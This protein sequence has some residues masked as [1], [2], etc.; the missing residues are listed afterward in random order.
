M[1]KLIESFYVD[2]VVSG[3]SDEEE[4]FKL[5]TNS[6]RILKKAAFNLQKFKTN[7]QSL[8][9]RIDTVEN[10]ELRTCKSVDDNTVPKQD[11]PNAA[12]NTPE[13]TSLALKVLG[14]TWDPQGDQLYFIVSQ[15]A[16]AAAAI[17]LTK[18]N[19]VRIIGKFYDPTGF[20][21]PV[22]IPFKRFFQK[23]CENQIQW[24]E[25][26]PNM[27][28]EEW[29]PLSSSLHSSGCYLFLEATSV[30][31]MKISVPVPYM[32]ASKSVRMQ[33]WF[34]F[35]SRPRRGCIL[36]LWWQRQELLPYRL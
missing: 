28:R 19:V 27:F 31:S 18:R 33:L 7:S 17:E 3:A 9:Q 16:E 35:T 14:V 13:T 23:L 6:K 26:L 36:S 29:E 1:P 30:K 22:I 32:D 5:Y 34:T 11:K 24:D 2:D 25:V 4:A 20:L 8:Q 12:D 10:L 15:V 21:A